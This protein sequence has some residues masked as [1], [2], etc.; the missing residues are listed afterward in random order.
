ML[1]SDELVAGER[2]E[3]V[4][5]QVDGRRV[6]R[7]ELGDVGVVSPAALDDVGGPGRDSIKLQVEAPEWRCEVASHL[8]HEQKMWV[9]IPTD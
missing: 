3:A 8:P 2:S 7:D 6:H 5:V 1:S 9:Q 4:A